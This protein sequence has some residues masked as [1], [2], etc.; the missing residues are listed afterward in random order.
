[1]LHFSTREP[2]HVPPHHFAALLP[3]S[4]FERVSHIS[5]MYVSWQQLYFPSV[6]T[7]TLGFSCYTIFVFTRRSKKTQPL[8]MLLTHLATCVFFALINFVTSSISLLQNLGCFPTDPYFPSTLISVEELSQQFVSVSG[9]CLALDRVLVMAAPIK[10][11]KLKISAKTSALSLVVNATLVAV[12]AGALLFLTPFADDAISAYDVIRYLTLFFNFTLLVEVLL[13][14]TFG[15]QFARYVRKQS[16]ACAQTN[17]V[18]HI[19]LF[20]CV[21]QTF[22]CIV[23]NALAIYNERVENWE[24]EWA[25]DVNEY[26]HVYFTTN[27]L[28]SVLF[29]LYKLK[30]KPPISRVVQSSSTRGSSP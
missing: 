27:V 25:N 21:S 2:R 23:P 4:L 15:I 6:S 3:A 16:A 10:Y 9:T 20:L 12:L 24:L 7:V 19:T 18:N 30:Q 13:H 29:T 26:N 17:R 28:L 11:F 22:F 5:A 1:M 8:G 14:V